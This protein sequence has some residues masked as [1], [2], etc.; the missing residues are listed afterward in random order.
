MGT[1]ILIGCLSALLYFLYVAEVKDRAKRRAK[2]KRK[3]LRQAKKIRRW[4][5]TKWGGTE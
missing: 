2:A 3:M 1:W 5:N 4:A